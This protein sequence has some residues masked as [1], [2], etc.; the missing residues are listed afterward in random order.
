MSVAVRLP[1]SG[2]LIYC[3]LRAG[4]RPQTL[5]LLTAIIGFMLEQCQDRCTCYGLERLRN[6]DEMFSLIYSKLYTSVRFY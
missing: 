3:A 5:C 2:V 6:M 4:P 1:V